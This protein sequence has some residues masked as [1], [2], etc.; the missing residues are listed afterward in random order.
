[1]YEMSGRPDKRAKHAKGDELS[2][3][4][5]FSQNTTTAMYRYFQLLIYLV[6][7]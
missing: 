7:K 1:M 6:K 4:E 3:A 5:P 2:K